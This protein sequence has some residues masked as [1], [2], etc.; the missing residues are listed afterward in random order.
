M[1]SSG[2]PSIAEIEQFEG[3]DALHDFAGPHSGKGADFPPYWV[4]L[5]LIEM[6]QANAA[7]YLFVCE[8]MQDIAEFDSS[9]APAAVS[10][11]QLKKKEN[12][13]WKAHL[14]TG[15]TVKS[16][17]PLADSPLMKLIGHVRSFKSMPA[18]GAF[19]SNSKFEV[20]LA[21]GQS[22]VNEE[23]LGLHLLDDAHSNG[24]K[25]SIAAAEGCQVADVE[26]QNIELRYTNLALDDMERHL[27]GVMF[28]F[29]QQVAPDH[30][31]QAHSLVESLFSKIKAR[32]RRTGKAATWAELAAK[33]GFGKAAFQQA[34]QA[35]TGTPDKSSARTRLFA[36]LSTAAGWKF[37]EE[38]SIQVGLAQCAR[39]KV[40]V[41]DGCRWTLDRV[42]LHAVCED[43][44][45]R[46]LS[47]LEFFEAVCVYLQEALPALKPAEIKALAIYEMVEWNPNPTLA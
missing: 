44:A 16:K 25:T 14:L 1:P 12:G 18:S 46:G 33:R 20:Q 8:Y 6:E 30:V 35:L 38:G 5:R 4:M 11:Y 31:N 9:S 27:T 37:Y 40:L 41:G 34:L 22:S 15:Q 36:K 28:D 39:E 42:G 32:S 3:D 2:S 21:S 23:A 29:I 10:L 19:V 45:A 26:L 24:L 43:A 13:Y 47:D 7:D 17:V